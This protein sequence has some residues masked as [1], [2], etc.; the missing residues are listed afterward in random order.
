MKTRLLV[1]LPLILAAPL[2]AQEKP[3]ASATPGVLRGA[4]DERAGAIK[5][6]LH[7]IVIPKIEFHDVTLR[8]A[9]DFLRRKSV[10]DDPD[11]NPAYRGVQIVLKEMPEPAPGQMEARD[12]GPAGRRFSLSMENAP[13]DAVLDR[14]AE[15]T[16]TK[17]RF[18]ADAVAIVPA[19]KDKPADAQA[20]EKM[21]ARL[22]GIVL[23]QTDFADATLSEIASFLEKRAAQVE[24]AAKDRP[25]DWKP[26]KL[27]V[28]DDEVAAAGGRVSLVLAN[29][30]LSE[31]LRYVADKTG[32]TIKVVPEG[33]VF[34]PRGGFHGALD[35]NPV[36]CLLPAKAQE[37]GRKLI[38]AKLD[39]IILP[40]LDF[41]EATLW[42]VL[43]FLRKKSVEMDNSVGD[44]N[45]R[46]INFELIGN[47]HQAGD[48]SQPGAMKISMDVRNV[49]MTNAL[50][51]ITQLSRTK[52]TID[53]YAVIIEPDPDAAK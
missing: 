38:A 34:V 12:T 47:A 17:V 44:P 26:L 9:V 41:R 43:E 8:E 27:D 39:H 52:F 13:L 1:F 14:I 2:F 35:S 48:A 7:R 6:V 37:A 22:N 30:P 16:R 32:T 15:L 21:V 4:D 18:D 42:D 19:D 3:D 10:E 40:Q 24:G 28:K 20:M 50:R 31:V 5:R 29:L 45:K 36:Q 23:G 51:S 33:V 25:A 49:S 53:P 46:G 11:P